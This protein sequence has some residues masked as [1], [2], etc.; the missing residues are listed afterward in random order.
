VS[1]RVPCTPCASLEYLV[2]IIDDLV[3]DRLS[4][5]LPLCSVYLLF[6]K[7]LSVVEASSVAPRARGKMSL[8]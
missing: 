7:C 8:I 5:G 6:L 2:I 4:L 1:P 3:D